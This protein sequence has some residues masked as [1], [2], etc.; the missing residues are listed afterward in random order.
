MVILILAAL[1][2]PLPTLAK[3]NSLKISNI[4]P[5]GE[6]V[7]S[8]RQIVIQFD[9]DVVPLGAMERAWDQVPVTITPTVKG[10]WRWLNTSALALQLNEA[11]K[12]HPATRYT[13]T[14]TPGI[15]ALDGT[16]LE[17]P[18]THHFTTL[19]PRITWVDFQAWRAPGIPVMGLHFNQP[20]TRESVRS[21]V[22]MV[23]NRVR[24]NDAMQITQV[25][26]EP[27]PDNLS[28]RIWWI[29]PE[30]ELP[31]DTAMVVQVSPGIVSTQGPEPGVEKRVVVEFHTFPEFKFL[32]L[33]CHTLKDDKPVII[34][35]DQFKND[36][37]RGT[38]DS[39][40]LPGMPSPGLHPLVNPKAYAELLFSAPV[41][42]QE[43]RDH[44][45]ITP[46]LAGDRKK[47]DPWANNYSGNLL[48][49]RYYPDNPCTI[50]LPE[51]LKPWQRYQLNETG[52]GIRDAFGRPLSTPMDFTFFTDHR[53]PDFQLLHPDGLLE[54]GV[55]SRLPMAVTN[56]EKIKFSYL[57]LLA[58][59]CSGTNSPSNDITSGNKEEKSS[60]D[61]HAETSPQTLVRDHL[62]VRDVTYH[63]PVNV[64][65]M[66][67][68]RSGAV[69]GQVVET[70]PQVKKHSQ[71]KQFFAQVTPW[72]VHAKIGHFNSLVWVTSL[73]TGLPV[74]G[75]KVSI[76]KDKMKH[77]TRT[78]TALAQGITD[79]NGVVM[80]PGIVTLDPDRT[81][82]DRWWEKGNDQRL[83]VKVEQQDDLALLAL[84]NRFTIDTW[85]VSGESF[86]ANTA[87]RNG[88]IHTWGTTAQGIYRAGDTIQYKIYVR[89]QDNTGFVRPP[90]T[91][92]T[93]T[94]LDPRGKT[95][96]TRKNI[97]LSRFGA[98]H[99]EYTV[100]KNGSVGWY[101]FEL[102]ANAFKQIWSPLRVLVSD[103]TPSPFKVVTELN[104]TSFKMEDSLIVTSQAS[105]HAG[106]PYTDANARVIVRLTEKTFHSAHP[107]AK[108]FSFYKPFQDA[109]DEDAGGGFHAHAMETLF[110][111]TDTLDNQGTL[112]NTILLASPQVAFGTLTVES[113][114]QDDRGKFVAATTTAPYLG[115]D[116]FVGLKS[117]Q[118]LYD[119]G[120][121][122]TLE[123]LVVDEKGTPVNDAEIS[124]RV[125]RLETSAVRVKGAGNAY[126]T[127]YH[128]QWITTH[129]LKLTPTTA[130]ALPFS[131]TPETPGDYRISATVTDTRGRS[132]TSGITTW[133][134]GRGHV[135][136]Q[137]PADY[138]LTIIPEKTTM[139]L[140]ETAKYLIKNPFPG[141]HA[142]IT[143]ER[144]G[145]LR[146]WVKK[147]ETATE[148]IEVP[149]STDLQPGFY[150]SATL[151]S[152]RVAHPLGENQV[153]LGKPT[154]RTGYVK[155][156]VTDPDKGIRVDVTPDHTVYKPGDTV[157]LDLQAHLPD[158][159]GTAADSP[160]VEFAVAVLDEAVF[161][162]ISGG[163]R[164]FDV[165]KGFYTLDG[166]D[167]SNYSLLT[168]IVGRRLF[169]KK[170]A[171][172]GGDGGAGGID[173]R[174]FFKFV[175]Y[176][177]PSLPTDATGHA[178]AT[179]T[180][181]DNL[182]GW[183][184]FAM[185]VTPDDGMG[186]GQG[187]FKVN[188]PTEIRPVM[189]NQVTA[190]DSFQAGF[191]VMNRTPAPRDLVV[192]ITVNTPGEINTPEEKSVKTPENEPDT[193]SVGEI[194]H[195]SV[196]HTMDGTSPITA[197]SP[198]H[199]RH[200]QKTIHLEPYKRH[201]VYLPVKTAQPGMLKFT[202]TA[203]DH[204]DGDG[205]V[206]TLKVIPKYNPTTSA[207]HGVVLENQATI[208][209]RYPDKIIPD[210]G[211][212][213]VL[214]SPTLLGNVDK[215]FTYMREYPYTCWEQ[216]LT[217][218][219]MAGHY[220]ALKNRL[221]DRVAWED[222]GEVPAKV[223]AQ[224]VSFQAPNGGMA[225]FKPENSRVSP[226]LSAYTALA[227]QWLKKQGYPLPQ[228]VEE[229]LHTYLSTLLKQNILPDF[230][231]KGMA[232]TVR[233]VALS[234]LAGEGKL[235]LADLDRYAP[236]VQRMSLFGKAQFLMAATRVEGG[237]PLARSTWE[238]ILS[239]SVQSSGKLKF[240]EILDRADAQ[241]LESSARTQGTILSAMIGYG[242][243]YH[244]Q[245]EIQD[246]ALKL[247]RTISQTRQ[248][249]GTWYNT[250]DNIF[251]LNGLLNYSRTFENKT[252]D[253]H[254][255]ALLNH[256]PMGE[257]RFSK[258]TD[259]PITLK[260]PIE[261]ENSGEN[262]TLVINKNG[263]GSLY[264]TAAVTYVSG[265]RSTQPVNAGM[266]IHKEISVERNGEWIL[267]TSSPAD[268][269]QIRQGE[270]VRTD[271]FISVLAACNFVVVDDPI[272]G[273][274]EPVNRDL[275]TASMVDAEKGTTARPDTRTDAGLQETQ[276]THA[277]PPKGS[278]WQEAAYRDRHDVSQWY[279]YHREMGHD[280]VRCY[281]DRLPPGNY[282]LSYTAQ[283][284]AR[285]TFAALPAQVLEMYDPD[286]FGKGVERSLIVT[287]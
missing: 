135:V 159:P 2:F 138:H 214:L 26:V 272:P 178:T 18:L 287:D 201:T 219:V 130:T 244:R 102:S 88:H 169:E 21:H 278:R 125:Q 92:Y 53:K 122:A 137:E 184:I 104:G 191:S 152:P 254:L 228:E 128:H 3:A 60:Q 213:Q 177:N 250:Q 41:A 265:E 149:V 44:V 171:N 136:W 160:P 229:Q 273:G 117:S 230:Y 164:H 82:F 266:E 207:T 170:G 277:W 198:D 47:Y 123:T 271:I 221:E 109:T 161:D 34:A 280:H 93:L 235:T 89:D 282:V 97:T 48:T 143:L 233:S 55:D 140:G 193:T 176:W 156:G 223:L 73:A 162:L 56:M 133:V 64:R 22:T 127:Q 145:V 114:V 8:S 286:V 227:F 268:P 124:I 4:T 32:G 150:F 39:T 196:E 269:I 28:G 94:L 105:L 107:E 90:Q 239:Q 19:R 183:R 13:I 69:Y 195:A 186:L 112:I 174:S 216:K 51:D 245:K 257:A 116:R 222:A 234:A 52:P 279:F 119:A 240:T 242:N 281:A 226:Y 36:Q 141:A 65:E 50:A 63:T 79:D 236:H 37:F 264:Y 204:V 96:L 209:I 78:T 120:Q 99:G 29:S 187:Q 189:P 147:L 253:M 5:G 7:Q 212:T 260:H 106:G 243:Q 25:V 101:R 275:A 38:D 100:P 71:E 175:S 154:F 66:L 168:H 67:N 237:E 23:R 263:P 59:P 205:T 241:L 24:K 231:S 77:L 167:V 256:I 181:P 210:T 14:V 42:F 84:N 155:T 261:K 70:T 142:L 40:P 157:T 172:V 217:R 192:S 274:L 15:T 132:H 6:N 218:A 72:Q 118:W 11:E 283:A 166:L 30:T 246:L 31:L 86:D 262:A 80:L 179:F 87:A 75:A 220:Q 259:P 110:E 258:I 49:T 9:R 194:A 57:S 121:P 61:Q 20:V 108:G 284:I 185:A 98:L 199:P 211:T 232:A 91:D 252:P 10:Q 203:R 17:K 1:L 215:A 248:G 285:G 224:A 62:M 43:I 33:R 202:A 144:Y 158:T 74:P 134:T 131:F 163:K 270:V 103:F 81:T 255:L 238:M 95:V 188:R 148:V 115:R 54:K 153:D 35:P 146:Q 85:Q 197:D 27:H 45:T 12:L 251:C 249:T 139:A 111:K 208:P 129:D 200:I 267:L 225:Y 182:T 83:F 276:D 76:H 58:T 165:H 173:M 180:V 190:G 16:T 247:V 151:I 113:A 126:L 46:D 206:H 68:G